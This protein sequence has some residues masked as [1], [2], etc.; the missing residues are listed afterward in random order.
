MP[1]N[2]ILNKLL[3]VRFI[4]IVKKTFLFSC[5]FS[6]TTYAPFL[7]PEHLYGKWCKTRAA[8]KIMIAIGIA[9]LL[10]GPPALA[11]D[12]IKL[13]LDDISSLGL[14]IESDSEV[15]AEG[16]GSIKITT[17]HPTTICLGEITG[18]VSE[19]ATLI[20]RARVKS[21]LEGEALLEMWVQVGSGRYFSRG[22]NSTIEGNSDWQIIQTPFVFQKGQ[23][24]GRITLNLMIN[25][26]GTVWIDDIVLSKSSPN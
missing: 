23:N 19:N 5:V 10:S 4:A 15:K 26:T 7:I 13:G 3:S 16:T 8:L 2:L 6:T 21:H 12:L 25:G 14:K 20:Y 11:E 17:L 18:L 24:P 9:L 1:M 22:L